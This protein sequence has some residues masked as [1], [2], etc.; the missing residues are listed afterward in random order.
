M[1]DSSRSSFLRPLLGSLIL[2]LGVLLVNACGTSQS[3]RTESVATK[4]LRLTAFDS[5]SG[6]PLDSARAVN[7]TFGDTLRTDSAGQF[8]LRDIEPALYVFDVGGYG[9]HTQR[10]VSVLVEPGDTAST[11]S[12]TLL[13]QRLNIRCKNNRP[14]FWDTVVN[15]YK[16]DSTRA[17][18]QLID[19]F[20]KD[21]E[22]QVQPVVVNDLSSPIFVPNN[23]GALGH[24]EIFLYD[25]N[26]NRL[27]YTYE[28]APPDEGHRI[29]SKGDIL[30]V[31]P[32]DLKRLE[33]STLIVGDSVEEGTTI[34][35]RMRYTFSFNDT[36]RATSAT[37]FPDLNLDSLQTPVFDTLRTDGAVE[38]PDSLV[39]Q[40]DTTIMRVVGIDTTVTRNGYTLFSTLRDG[41]AATNAQ[42]ARNLLYVPDSVIARARRDSIA[43]AAAMDTTVP[44]VD[45]A[46]VAFASDPSRL[47]IVERTNTPGLRSLLSDERLVQALSNGL[48]T[49]DM[50]VDSLLSF[51]ETFRRAYLQTPSLSK[52]RV[53][54]G[55]NT[56]PDS[57]QMDSV[58]LSAPAS[59]SLFRLMAPDSL[60]A[61]DSSSELAQKNPFVKTDPSALFAP[62]SDSIT[63]DSLRLTVP[64]TTDSV[65][66]KSIVTS[67]LSTPPAYSYWYLS[68]SVSGTESRV[69]VVDSSFFQLRARPHVDTT[70]GID[71]AG[72]LPK[73]VGEREQ[74][75]L[76]RYPQQVV[77]A[78]AG[79]Y[80]SSY[81]ETWKALQEDRLKRHYCEVFSFPLQSEWRSASMQ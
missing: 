74:D 26:S 69:L 8:V 20:A 22:V 72:L 37:T 12:T 24:Y 28:N 77:R 23:F 13:P 75:A 49:L 21:G 41:N 44:P 81:L 18:I 59:D 57:A 39:L 32:K 51:S 4:T 78:P 60:A 11:A 46:A 62:E 42:A 54:R 6:T 27:S 53:R 58:I 9:Y 38:V 35:A 19:V 14:Y 45:T 66:T 71:L 61:P 48:P 76:R 34:F 43:R 25:G 17:R 7:R 3:T 52:S 40:R 15:Q 16:K 5:T 29:Y 10:Y 56:V 80:R 63:I 70:A 33:P 73:R 79:T 68:P 50:T 36:L 1:S 2:A 64:P 30:P 31:V 67:T 55:L 65:A 47:Q